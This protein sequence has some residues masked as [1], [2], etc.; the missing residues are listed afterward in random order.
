[1][2]GFT[3]TGRKHTAETKERISQSRKGKD[4]GNDHG[5]TTGHEPYNKGKPHNVHTPEWR[6]KVSKAM[7]GE[8]HW[9]WKGGKDKINRLMRS[10]AAHK[11]WALSVY[12]NDHWTC[13]ICGYKGKELIAHHLKSWAKH[14]DLRFDVFNGITYCRACHCQLHSPRTGTGKSSIKNG[15]NSVEL[16][17]G[18]A[19]D[20]T[21]PAG[22]IAKGSPGVCDGQG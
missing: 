12:R 5:F 14:P 18:Y 4:L 8:N 2:R 16:L 11:E 3:F 20:N 10:S 22:E 7:S 1:M 15:F 9:N 19:E 6:E 21:E 17:T 13:Q